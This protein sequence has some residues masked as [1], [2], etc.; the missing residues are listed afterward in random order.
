MR[1]LDEAKVYVRSGDGGAGCVSFRREK[2]EP[3]GGPNGGDG[4]RGGDVIAECVE[5]LNTLVDYRYR[6]HFKAQ[7]GAHGMGRDRSGCA[8]ASVTLKLPVGTQIMEDD[9]TTLICDLTEPGQRIVLARGGDGGRGNAAFKSSTRRAPRVAE[10]GWPAVEH[11]LWLR[12]KLVADVGLVGLPNAGKS[13]LLAAVSH[14]RPKVADYP[15]TTLVPV[16]GVVEVDGDEFVI[17]DIP[18]LIEGAHQGRGLGDRFLGHVERCGV[19]VHLVDGTQDPD[20]IAASYRTVRDELVAYGAG[21][22]ERDEILVLNKIDALAEADRGAAIEALA[23]ASRRKV[24]TVS[25]VA[26]TGVQGLLHL[27]MKMVA[28]RRVERQHR[29]VPAYSP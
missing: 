10:P 1:F 18:G 11:W 12:L 25:G 3:R 17:A 19:L 8:G 14:A 22:A 9:K 7:R 6:Q 28:A 23:V 24:Q 2:F 21:L 29:P 4:G 5:A 27:L 26:G 15:F 13:T 20:A 16:L